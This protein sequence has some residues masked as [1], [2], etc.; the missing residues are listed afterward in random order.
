M[1]LN[2]LNF[3]TDLIDEVVENHIGGTK[4]LLQGK[5]YSKF[6]DPNVS[7]DDYKIEIAKA[8]EGICNCGFYRDIQ[9][10]MSQ[11]VNNA[12]VS[13]KC[14]EQAK[15]PTIGISKLITRNENILEFLNALNDQIAVLNESY[16]NFERKRIKIPAELNSILRPYLKLLSFGYKPNGLGET[17]T[18]TGLENDL[19]ELHHELSGFYIKSDLD[20]FKGIFGFEPYVG[21]IVWLGSDDKSSAI[22]LLFFIMTLYEYDLITVIKDRSGK[23]RPNYNWIRKCFVKRDLSEFNENFKSL[24]QQLHKLSES[25]RLVIDNIL[26]N[27]K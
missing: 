18:Y 9:E 17:F 5:S 21:P 12:N 6:L 4:I 14:L 3:N 8:I 26:L 1:E 15:R 19:I 2:A 24:K 11:E 25:K 16:G 7:F 22:E 13:I 20:A 10:L 23:I 27:Y